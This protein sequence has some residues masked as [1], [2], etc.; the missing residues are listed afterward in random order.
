MSIGKTSPMRATLNDRVARIRL[1]EDCATVGVAESHLPRML[2]PTLA[3]A[4]VM[5]LFRSPPAEEWRRPMRNL[6]MKSA[7][8]KVGQLVT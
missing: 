8:L 5:T 1:T 2:R 7:S 3:P 6:E 4:P